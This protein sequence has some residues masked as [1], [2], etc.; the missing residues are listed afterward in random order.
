MFYLHLPG[1]SQLA[2]AETSIWADI[3]KVKLSMITLVTIADSP[4][5][6]V[7]MTAPN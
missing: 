7:L 6:N 5:R 3:I 2:R 1:D 4:S